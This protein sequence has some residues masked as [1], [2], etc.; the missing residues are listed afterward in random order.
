MIQKIQDITEREIERIKQEMNRLGTP[1]EFIFEG[2]TPDVTGVVVN[3]DEYPLLSQQ[4]HRVETTRKVGEGSEWDK[5]GSDQY[6][7]L[8]SDDTFY[9]PG[10]QCFD[11]SSGVYVPTILWVS[12]G[13]IRNNSDERRTIDVVGQ[14]PLRQYVANLEKSSDITQNIRAE[15]LKEIISRKAGKDGGDKK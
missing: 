1:L 8:R 15:I 14:W 2:K 10:T 9:I 6:I 13:T 4:G 7:E 11:N 12:Y 5:R 3:S